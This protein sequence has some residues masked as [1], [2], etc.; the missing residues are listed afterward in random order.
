MKI[1]RK[2]YSLP[3]IVGGDRETEPQINAD[4]RTINTF[5]HYYL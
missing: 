1:A 3:M 5:G 4:E 2:N